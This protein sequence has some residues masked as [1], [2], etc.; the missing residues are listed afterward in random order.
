[1]LAGEISETPFDIPGALERYQA[2]MEPLIHQSQKLPPGAPQAANPQ[3]Q[4]GICIL[5]GCLAIASSS[6][7]TRLV[8]FLTRSTSVKQRA[9]VYPKFKNIVLLLI[10][11][12]SIIMAIARKS[13]YLLCKIIR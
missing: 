6:W 12:Q 4:I 3:T 2:A 13:S 5:H 11:F 8:S 1:M 10:P 9:P 7:I